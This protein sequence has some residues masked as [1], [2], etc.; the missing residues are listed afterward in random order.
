VSAVWRAF[1]KRRLAV[2]ALIVLL[3]L[4]SMAVLADELASDL[5][6]VA[7]V[8]GQLFVLPNVF[9]PAS[10]RGETLDS[11]RQRLQPGDWLV[12]PV[13]PY[14]PNRTKTHSALADPGWEHWLGTDELGR[15]V[16][17][18]IVHGARSTLTVGFAAVAFCVLI[19][20]ALGGVAGLRGGA[21]DLVVSR[22]VEGVRV[23]PTFLLVLCVLGSL[24][25]RTIWPMVAVLGLTRWTDV[26][27]LVRADVLR[28]KSEPF[29]QASRALGAGAGRVLLRHLLPNALGP[30]LVAAT[31][32]IA[33][34]VLVETALSFLGFGVPP[35]APSWGELLSEA[36][37]YVTHPGAWWLTVFPGLAIFL[38]VTSLNLVAEALRDAMDPRLR[39]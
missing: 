13:V 2:G 11:L 22:A 27:R 10:L 15:D 8:Q 5:P 25:V 4:F 19:G 23:F 20:V 35:P 28:L 7:R 30:V 32:G 36:H 37:R 33:S 6:V 34:A 16:F 24:R 21:F 18:R 17:A 38:T 9:P 12:P 1:R 39:S 31:F 3:G 29:V 14:G 26:A